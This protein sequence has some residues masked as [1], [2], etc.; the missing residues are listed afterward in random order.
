MKRLYI[1]RGANSQPYRKNKRVVYFDDKTKAKKVRDK[2]NEETTLK[3]LG[4]CSVKTDADIKEVQF[5]N[6]KKEHITTLTWQAL[7]SLW[8]YHVSPGPDHY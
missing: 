6:K 2:L 7:Q 3:V 4:A 1:I 5:F 8:I